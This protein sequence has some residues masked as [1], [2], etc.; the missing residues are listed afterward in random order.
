MP[1]APRLK[2]KVEI[3]GL[4]V[5]S[6]KQ[7]KPRMKQIKFKNWLDNLYMNRKTEQYREN[8]KQAIEKVES[9]TNKEELYKV[10]DSLTE[11][12]FILFN[13]ENPH[14]NIQYIYNDP[15]NNKGKQLFA[16]FAS[17][18]GKTIS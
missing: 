7:R 11:E 13:T 1:S 15:N 17:Y 9:I 5:V 16:I 2:S 18:I 4:K 8:M 14:M 3:K 6:T 12:E 10:L